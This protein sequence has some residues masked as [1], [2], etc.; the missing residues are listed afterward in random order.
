MVIGHDEQDIGT[1][2]LLIWRRIRCTG[3]RQCR[4]RYYDADSFRENVPQYRFHIFRLMPIR[5]IMI[6]Y[7]H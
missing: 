4:Q 6:K 1:G 7:V 5:S 3:G 2:I